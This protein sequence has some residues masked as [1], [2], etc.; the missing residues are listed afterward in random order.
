MHA[1]WCNDYTCYLCWVSIYLI[2]CWCWC[3]IF[4]WYLLSKAWNT[5]EY[6]SFKLMRKSCIKFNT[7]LKLSWTLKC[8]VLSC[9]AYSSYWSLFKLSLYNIITEPIN[10]IVSPLNILYKQFSESLLHLSTC[11][12]AGAS[13]NCPQIGH[14]TKKICW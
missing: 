11:V 14:K 5:H 8:L 1:S 4:C 13:G 3:K 9:V 12:C 6:L 10:V 7:V 2:W